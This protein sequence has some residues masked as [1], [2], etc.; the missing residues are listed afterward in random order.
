MAPTRTARLAHS[1]RIPAKAPA[2]QQDVLWRQKQYL[3]RVRTQ[4]KQ[5]E[6]SSLAGLLRVPPGVAQPKIDSHLLALAALPFTR[7]SILD[8]FCGSGVVGLSVASRATSCTFA[9]ISPVAIR[10]C[11]D[12]ARDLRIAAKLSYVVGAITH[13]HHTQKYDLIVASPPYT[14]LNAFIEG[15]ERGA[16]FPELWHDLRRGCTVVFSSELAAAA[17]DIETRLRELGILPVATFDKL[18]LVHGGYVHADTILRG[19]NSPL[20]LITSESDRLI[21]DDVFNSLG[22]S[23]KILRVEFEGS[24]GVAA[25]CALGWSIGSFLKCQDQTSKLPD[26]TLPKWGRDLW[27]QWR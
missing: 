9:D 18:D 11:A 15:L 23:T 2:T 13:Q 27:E 4:R 6:F 3:K 14:D 5:L 25:S 10:A 12:N 22:S 21:F 8:I 16:N 19:H 1:D 17:A 7:G 26:P 20:L 24:L